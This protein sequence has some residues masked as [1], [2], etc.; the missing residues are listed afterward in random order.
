MIK[1]INNYFLEN[2]PQIWNVR[3]VP[4]TALILLL[5]II[6]WLIGFSSYS[7][8][9]EIRWNS[10]ETL[11]FSSTFVMYSSIGSF[12]VFI[13]WLIRYFRNNAFKSFYPLS[14]TQLFGQFIMIFVISFLNITYYYSY[15]KGYMFHATYQR[16]YATARK[17]RALFVKMHPLVNSYKESY[18]VDRKCSPSPFPMSKKFRMEKQSSGA[19]TNIVYYTGI[20]GRDYSAADRDKMTGG[21]QYS[22]LN[23]C[24]NEYYGRYSSNDPEDYS[25]DKTYLLLANGDSLKQAMKDFLK[26]CDSHGVKYKIDVNEWYKWVYNPP[27]FPVRYM[28]NNMREINSYNNNNQNP[29][30]YY[31]ELDKLSRIMNNAVVV[32]EYHISLQSLIAYLYV[33]LSFA[34]IIFSFRITSRRIWL[35]SIIGSALLALIVGLISAMIVSGSRGSHG[36][37]HAVLFFYLLLIASFLVVSLSSSSK[38]IANVAF[39]WFSWSAPFILPLLTAIF[40]IDNN[41]ASSSWLGH[42]YDIF[43]VINC[44]AYLA[45]IWAL[46]PLSRRLQAMPED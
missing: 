38:T 15:T 33:S 42:H 34:I 1:K 46:T 37:G 3:F 5:H 10:P 23:Y 8:V 45:S 4:Y 11:F 30:G 20:D 41:D 28:I 14:N 6:H 2:Y 16:D 24:Q 44:F 43:M 7:G 17:E 31:I 29:G 9:D 12:I 36:T 26:L 22:Y 35:I 19:D 32:Y 21:F 39:T 18:D 40:F 25:I 27:Y 13:L